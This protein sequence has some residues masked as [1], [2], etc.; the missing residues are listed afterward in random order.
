[1]GKMGDYKN[2]D[3][4]ESV[5]RDSVGQTVL[6]DM[7]GVFIRKR[8]YAK[9]NIKRGM[10]IIMSFFL[11]LAGLNHYYRKSL[12]SEY[13]KWQKDSGASSFIIIDRFPIWLK[14]RE[15]VIAHESD[16][17]DVELN[18]MASLTQSE[19]ETFSSS[20]TPEM[21][22]LSGDTEISKLEVVS[23]PHFDCV[24][25]RT[26]SVLPVMPAKFDWRDK[27]AVMPVRI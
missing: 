24:P 12:R 21:I 23:W 16:S 9:R 14:S 18:H 25:E 10:F 26:P 3:F 2:F 22:R 5:S 6:D 13:K 1:M 8:M 17:Y 11:M 27:N 4:E 19:Y 15:F 7:E 20:L